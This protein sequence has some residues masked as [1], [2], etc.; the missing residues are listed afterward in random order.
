[1][2]LDNNKGAETQKHAYTFAPSTNPDAM[3]MQIESAPNTD[4][5]V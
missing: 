3:N 2:P 5:P 4:E 1:M